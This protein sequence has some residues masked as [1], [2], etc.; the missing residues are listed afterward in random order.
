M[1]GYNP[2]KLEELTLYIALRLEGEPTFGRTKL[3]KMLFFAD[4]AAYCLLGKAITAAHYIKREF[5]PCPQPFPE[6]EQKLYASKRAHERIVPSGPFK[7][8]RMVALDAPNLD[9]FTAAEIEIVSEVIEKHRADTA[10]DVSDLSHQF[11]GWQKTEIGEEIPYFTA[12]LPSVP[13]ALSPEEKGRA[14][15]EADRI[16]GVAP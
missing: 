2:S 11:V 7:Q 8:R 5:G 15:A 12:L 10:N 14:E 3:V 4:F 13:R 9:L 6:I 1:A 16:F